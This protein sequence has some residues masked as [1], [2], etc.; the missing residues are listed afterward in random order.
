MASKES[1]NPPC[2]GSVRRRRGAVGWGEVGFRGR[3][4]LLPPR[5]GVETWFGS[6]VGGRGGGLLGSR[7]RV[8]GVVVG[9]V[10]VLR[11]MLLRRKGF[12]G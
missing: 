1:P 4:F 10:G 8:V 11:M 7:L 12:V 9:A 2:A 6:A 3:L 5:I